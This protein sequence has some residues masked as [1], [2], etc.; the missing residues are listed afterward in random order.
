MVQNRTLRRLL[1]C[2]FL[3]AMGPQVARAGE[4]SREDNRYVAVTAETLRDTPFANKV[5]RFYVSERISVLSDGDY[6]PCTDCHDNSSQKSNPKVRVLKDEHE[7]LKLNHGGGRIWCLNCHS[8]QNRDMLQGLKQQMISFNFSFII[9]GQCHF[10]Q[11]DDFIHGV[12]GKR[13]YRWQGSPVL[14]NCVV[15]HDPH[16]PAFKK[17][18][19]WQAPKVRAGLPV[20]PT[21]EHYPTDPWLQHKGERSHKLEPSERGGVIKRNHEESGE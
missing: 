17:R 9:C 10:R 5:R 16:D 3:F 21:Y 6:Y 12:H 1:A 11:Q 18:Y 14:Q 8:A 15:C 13:L 7:D 4:S 19:P 2:F 20:L